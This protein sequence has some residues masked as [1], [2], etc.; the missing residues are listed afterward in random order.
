MA[1]AAL[2]ATGVAVGADV[3]AGGHP[4]HTVALGLVG[5][6]VAVLRLRLAGEHLGLFAAL[7]AAF[8]AQPVL[9]ATVTILPAVDHAPAPAD[10]AAHSATDASVTAVHLVVAATIMVAVAAVELLLLPGAT[11]TPLIRL[12]HRFDRVVEPPL[13]S[14]PVVVA[15]AASARRW[16]HIVHTPRRGPPTAFETA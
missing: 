16:V 2:L 6:L 1:A 10:A 4:L 15:P 9:H 14:D 3:V 12:V 11:R 7:T 8:L 13:A 5:V